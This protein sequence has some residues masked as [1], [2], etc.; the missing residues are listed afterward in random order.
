MVSSHQDQPAQGPRQGCSPK[1]RFS[2]ALF[3][4]ILTLQGSLWTEEQGA[5]VK[6]GSILFHLRFTEDSF[7]VSNQVAYECVT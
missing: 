2:T 1:H 5:Q 3:S 4:K 6:Q 7:W